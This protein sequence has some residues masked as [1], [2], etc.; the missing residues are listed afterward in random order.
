MLFISIGDEIVVLAEYTARAGWLCSFR[1]PQQ[2]AMC[3]TWGTGDAGRSSHF[4]ERHPRAVEGSKFC[5]YRGK[6]NELCASAGTKWF[7][8]TTNSSPCLDQNLQKI[9]EEYCPSRH[10][11]TEDSPW[12]T[13][14]DLEF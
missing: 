7:V 6:N 5:L 14:H 2:K 12:S 3:Q 4:G 11:L 1:L 8:A 9:V 13:H 10:L